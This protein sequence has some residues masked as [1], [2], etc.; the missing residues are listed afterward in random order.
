MHHSVAQHCQLALELAWQEHN[1]LVDFEVH[2]VD[3]E[4]H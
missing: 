3:F 4:V 2:Q 1:H